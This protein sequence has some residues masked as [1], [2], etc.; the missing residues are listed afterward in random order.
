MDDPNR[1]ELTATALAATLGEASG[2]DEEP[3]SAQPR[4]WVG[5]YE[6]LTLLG[7]GGMGSVYAAH[8]PELDRRVAVKVLRRDSRSAEN[9]RLIREAR[10]LARLSHPNIVPVFDVGLDGET[11][12]IVMELVDGRTVARWFKE[13]RPNVRDALD[14]FLAAGRGLVAAHAAGVVHRDFKPDNMMLGTDGRVRVLDFGLA[15]AELEAAAAATLP[16]G[17][18]SLSGSASTRSNGA[19]AASGS[20]SSLDALTD[21]HLTRAGA[22]LG[23]PAYMAPEQWRGEPADARTD[24]FSFCVAL[25]EALYGERPFSGKTPQM[26]MTAVLRGE[27]ASDRVPDRRVPAPVRAALLRGLSIAPASRHANMSALLDALEHGERRRRRRIL[28]AGLALVGCLA[29]ALGVVKQTRIAACRR[30]GEKIADVWDSSARARLHKVLQ[31]S[32]VGFAETT[33]EKATEHLDAWAAA[34]START[35]VCADAEVNGIRSTDEGERATACLEEQRDRVS[36]LLDEIATDSR[37]TSLQSFLPAVLALPRPDACLD[38]AHLAQRAETPSDVQRRRTL[39]ELRRGQVGIEALSAAGHYRD[40]LARAKLLLANA[41]AFGD[42]RFI[43]EIRLLIGSLRSDRTT[44]ES[45]EQVFVE[46]QQIGADELAA[47][48]ATRLAG[49]VGIDLGRPEEG[50]QWALSA[51]VVLR[52]LGDVDGLATARALAA[53]GDVLRSRGTYEDAIA[54]YRRALDIRE[55]LLGPVHPEVAKTLNALANLLRDYGKPE[56]AY[57]ALVRALEIREGSLGADHPEVAATWNNLGLLA[58]LR[59][60]YDEAQ[61]ALERSLELNKAAFGEKTLETATVL[62]NLG[63]LHQLRGHFDEAQQML[64]AALLTR[65]RWLGPLDLDVAITLQNLGLL[66][67]VRGDRL[68]A[69]EHLERV[70]RIRERKMEDTNPEMLNV[71]DS[72]GHLN[73]RI[74]DLDQAQALHERALVIQRQ[75]FGARHVNVAHSLRGLAQVHAVRGEEDKAAAFAR[76]ALDIAEETL[77]SEHP[78]LPPF[79]NTSGLVLRSRDPDAARGHL[80]RALEL[81]RR[82]KGDR[83]PATA[84]SLQRLGQLE[85]DRGELVSAEEHL[86]EARTIREALNPTAPE[87]S[88]VQFE[89][90]RLELAR[91]RPMAAVPWLESAVQL[92]LQPGVPAYHLGEA[93]HLLARALAPLD[94]ARSRRLALDAIEAFRRAGA[95]FASARAD[96]ERWLAARR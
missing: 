72:L 4:T 95:P 58:Q 88:D 62:N 21:P 66:A 22:L 27:L 43:L 49:I 82:T 29:G 14:V 73:F 70:L 1:A 75:V 51:D 26:L 25:W 76:E 47:R 52:R 9:A 89:L 77:G 86:V 7:S 11:L 65:E 34:W 90:G 46:A 92:R 60:N 68:K 2:G 12:Y 13:S 84:L 5:R 38:A 32:G 41:E 64:E 6:L 71:L 81:S 30:A 36:V 85:I 59:G 53:R 57:P 39:V 83:H 56:E 63:R 23:T 37:P 19:L 69:R 20:R 44:A 96:V 54:Q 45:L 16:D 87:L 8:D 15:R 10:T 48:A 50:L 91:G 80:A 55:R 93:E 79:L 17:R 94:S 33:D 74:G 31:R 3:S 67:M 18:A 35:A 24:Q 61:R 78:E 40:A 42:R 28:L